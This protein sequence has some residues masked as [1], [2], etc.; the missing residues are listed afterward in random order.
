MYACVRV[1]SF[2]VSFGVVREGAQ[3]ELQIHS[4]P[5][6]LYL[7]TLTAEFTKRQPAH[8]YRSVATLVVSGKSKGCNVFHA[9]FNSGISVD[10]K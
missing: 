2:N 1:S 3:N 8:Q 7:S 6:Q 9:S 5:P 4:E 10:S